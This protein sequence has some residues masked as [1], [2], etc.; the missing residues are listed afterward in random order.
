MYFKN[1]LLNKVKLLKVIYTLNY[2]TCFFLFY[3]VLN[4]LEFI[5]VQ[6]V[7]F[8]VSNVMV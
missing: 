6:F 5:F 3:F 8:V 1:I 2:G 4:T 7:N